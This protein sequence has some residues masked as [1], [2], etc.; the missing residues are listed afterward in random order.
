MAE[1]YAQPVATVL[2][3]DMRLVR[4]LYRQI[5][6]R[7]ARRILEFSAAIGAA[8]DKDAYQAIHAAAFPPPK[9]R[10]DERPKTAT[11]EN[12]DLAS[13]LMGLPG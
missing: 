2:A 12:K 10:G 4:S 5:P 7:A 1:I 3:M 9:D 13:W 8:F 11:E 6:E